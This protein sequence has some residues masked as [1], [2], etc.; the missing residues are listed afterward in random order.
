MISYAN[1]PQATDTFNDCIWPNISILINWSDL[2]IKILDIPLCSLPTITAIL[3][4]KL[5]LLIEIALSDKT[6][7]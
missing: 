6:E 1:I 3:L 4:G 2:S 5:I 7:A